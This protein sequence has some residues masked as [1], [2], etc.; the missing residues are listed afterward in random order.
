MFSQ[1]SLLPDWFLSEPGRALIANQ[2]QALQ[3]LLPDQFYKVAL[4]IGLG[5]R[6]LVEQMN[7]EQTIYCDIGD[8]AFKQPHNSVIAVPEALPFPESSV[9]LA[10]MLHT[11]DYCDA[12]HHALREIAQ[13]LSPEGVLVLTGFHP[14]S[15]W[16][17]K[18]RFSAKSGPFEARFLSRSVVQDWLELLGFQTVSG[19]MLNYQFPALSHHWRRRLA[20][21]DHAG[22]RW[23]PTMG[24][25]Y[26][27]VVKKH[28]YGGIAL[29]Q[30]ARVRPKWFGA[31]S[32]SQAKVTQRN[33]K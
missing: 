12:P 31:A 1:N 32:P 26:V 22:D 10:L 6:T 9:D 2:K 14:Y 7:I 16:G 25:V 17:L 5:D 30:P 3:T 28:V 21:M 18:R 23:W 29:R 33:A 27:L 8:S 19:C 13:L 20:W 11:L 24:A 4:Q 15:L